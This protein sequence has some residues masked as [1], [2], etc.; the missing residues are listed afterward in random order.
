[1]SSSD[2]TQHCGRRLVRKGEIFNVYQARSAASF[3][4][5]IVHLSLLIVVSIR[6]LSTLYA[7]TQT[8]HPAGQLYQRCAPRTKVG[9]SLSPVFASRFRRVGYTQWQNKRAPVAI[10]AKKPALS[11]ASPPCRSLELPDPSL[12]HSRIFNKR[13]RRRREFT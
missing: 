5:E 4:S 1:M 11:S 6:Q 12:V 13:Y 9:I 7:R 2:L 8:N 10:L 3:L